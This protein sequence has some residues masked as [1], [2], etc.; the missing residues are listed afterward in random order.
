VRTVRS[1]TS[2]KHRFDVFIGPIPPN[3]EASKPTQGGSDRFLPAL[4]HKLLDT[5]LIVWVALR[6]LNLA[7]SPW[8]AEG[9]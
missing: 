3:A 9:A 2:G 6:S 8:R 5:N 7:Y 4:L 1:V